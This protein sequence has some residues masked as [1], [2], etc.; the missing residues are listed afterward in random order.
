MG[1]QPVNG[2]YFQRAPH[3]DPVEGG[4]A[5]PGVGEADFQERLSCPI[6]EFRWPTSWRRRF[7]WGTAF[8]RAW[9]DYAG[10]DVA[11]KTVVMLAGEPGSAEKGMNYRARKRP[12]KWSQD[13]SAQAHD[14]GQF[15]GKGHFG[16]PGIRTLKSRL[17]PWL[18]RERMRLDVERQGEGTDLPTLLV[19]EE[20]LLR[21][22]RV[23]VH[24]RRCGRNGQSAS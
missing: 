17:V 7:L 24:E 16:D 8:K 4:C 5:H 14:G 10:L 2:S 22:Y 21:S 15:G 6:Q 11:G 19:S 3:G 1:L 13:P 9:D 23:E 20:V 12:S 18:S